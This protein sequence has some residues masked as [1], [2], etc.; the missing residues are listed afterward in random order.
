MN[1]RSNLIS[2]TTYLSWHALMMSSPA[3]IVP[4]L[5]Q[6]FDRFFDALFPISSM[7]I[8]SAAINIVMNILT[9]EF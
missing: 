5:E 6:L 9:R 2:P 7:P 1:I 8:A 3:L 4:E